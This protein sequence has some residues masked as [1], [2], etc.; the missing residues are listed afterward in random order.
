M[1]QGLAGLLTM[2]KDGTMSLT[3]DA[4]KQFN[5]AV[6]PADPMA[7]AN[8]SKVKPPAG[9]PAADATTPPAK[10]GDTYN[11]KGVVYKGAPKPGDR[12][13]TEQA[14]SDPDGTSD[15]VQGSN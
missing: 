1:A 6:N 11:I 9:T 8:A 7:G 12:V 15:V 4:A 10:S 5:A 2:G 13:S 14:N 3:G